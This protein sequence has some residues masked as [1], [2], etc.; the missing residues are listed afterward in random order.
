MKILLNCFYSVALL[1][2]TGCSNNDEWK[3]TGLFCNN[4]VSPVG[5]E[6]NPVFHWQIDVRNNSEKLIRWELKLEA[7]GK[8]KKFEG[9]EGN[10]WI[11]N[12][13]DLESGKKYIW[14][15]RLVDQQGRK[16]DWSQ[17][18]SFI[19]GIK[20]KEWTNANWIAFEELPDSMKIIPAV[21]MSGDTLGEKGLRRPIIPQFRR[22]FS[23]SKKIEGAYLFIS[24][25]GHYSLTID[26]KSPDDRFLAPGWTLF[27]KTCYY[28]GYDITNQ[29]KPGKHAIGVLVGNGFFNVNRERYRKL[30]SA[31]GMP[32][33]RLKL[34]IRYTDGSSEELNSDENWKTSASPITFTS[35]YGGEDFDARLRQSGWNMPGF[36]DTRWK[37]VLI[38]K[39][40]GGIMKQEEDYP[41][42]IMQTFKPENIKELTDST[43]V[44]DFGQNASGIPE[45]RVSGAANRKVRLTPGEVINDNGSVNQDGSGGPM[46]FDY[47]GAGNNAETW[48]P[49]FTYYGFRYIAITG[50][51]PA[52]FPNPGNRP[53]VEEILFHHTRNSAPV[54]GN[55]RC[56]NDLFNRIFDLINWGVR[57]NLASVTT[58]CPHREK[59]GWLE[60]THLMGTSIQYAYDIRSLYSKIVND[61]MDS[62]LEN[63]LVPDI[64]PEYVHFIDGFRDSPEWGSSAVILP[65]YLYQW[66]GDKRPMEQAWSMMTRY[67]EYLQSTS[68]K[69]IL[70]HGLGDW[71]DLGPKYVG[72]AQLTP[73]SLT[74]TSIY[75]YDLTIL[76]E[77]AS[78]LNKSDESLYYK[79]SADKV[80]AAFLKRFYN[81][82][83]HEI[84]NGSQTSFAMPLVV[85][86]IDADIRPAVYDAFMQTIK[87]D[88]YSLTAG[89][90]GFHYL[91]RAL[92]DAGAHDV[93]W[94]M[95]SRD[96]VPG[97][98][99]QLRKGATALTESWPA[100]R[101]VSNNHMML[102]HL[103]EWFFSGIGGIKQADGSVGYKRIIID[104]QPVGDLTWA[105]VSHT[106][107][108]GD[109]YVKWEIKN[110]GVAMKIKIPFD[111]EADVKFGGQEIG[112]YTSGTYYIFT[113]KQN[114]KN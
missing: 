78:I 90:I 60:Q 17:T 40:P 59:L 6:G 44:Y 104:P 2:V 27:S 57:S 24:G 29:L 110:D 79:K 51:V 3:I 54:A 13:S 37:R 111:C 106:C 114:S 87:R 107:I 36:D 16:T 68:D 112:K 9:V 28:N 85:G 77:M 42:K 55:F 15:V 100:H 23:V 46:Y 102:G 97:Y 49:T 99:Y 83:T 94:K 105:E 103:M 75:F 19:T 84:A 52:G 67:V 10:E 7:H 8:I 63:G 14:K 74:A 66:Y 26:G 53:V 96:D 38:V 25:L 73:V 11:Y 82:V 70:S 1:L 18:A 71:C 12:G 95:N 5:V 88:G 4:N 98:G 89:D 31:W 34:L 109:I 101:F 56:S 32:M 41:M 72:F 86:L 21:H 108:K 22:E 35:I 45:I 61:M 93:I 62:Q 91:V 92:Q 58:D 47:I 33:M 30:V 39:G 69:G 80:K 65:W 113:K 76:S 64:A 43:Y 20:E 48:K 81:P 50:A